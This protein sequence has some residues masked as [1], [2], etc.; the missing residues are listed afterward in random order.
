MLLPPEFLS[1]GP[2]PP[3]LLGE[4]AKEDLGGADVGPV[5]GAVGIG[6][7]IGTLREGN[8]AAAHAGGQDVAETN[9]E[10]K[11]AADQN[12]TDLADAAVMDRFVSSDR[13]EG[14]PERGQWVR[15]ACDATYARKSVSKTSPRT[16]KVEARQEHTQPILKCLWGWFEGVV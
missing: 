11:E 15:G 5:D 9:D 14:E 8:L 4:A 7:P 1:H 3:S 6:A 10:A 12:G 16:M 13:R 2:I